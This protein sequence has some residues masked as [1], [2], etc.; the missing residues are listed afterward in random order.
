MK[1]THEDILAAVENAGLSVDLSSIKGD[2]S[3]EE[4]GLDS[5]DSMTF[6]LGIEEKFSV[7]IPDEDISA[8]DTIDDIITYIGRS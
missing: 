5:L 8:L 4:A 3:L 2:D 1:V 6:F 7:K